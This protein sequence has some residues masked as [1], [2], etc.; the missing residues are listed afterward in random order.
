MLCWGK[1]WKMGVNF[2][3]SNTFLNG[4]RFVVCAAKLDELK[5]MIQVFQGEADKK[6]IMQR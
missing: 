2:S 5:F 4:R 1:L 6:F 3:L